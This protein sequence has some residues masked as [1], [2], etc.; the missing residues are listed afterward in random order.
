RAAAA[1]LEGRIVLISD[2]SPSAL[3]LP[4]TL[5]SLMQTGDDYYGNFEIASLLRCIRFSAIFLAFSLPGLYLAVT[6][7]HPQLLPTPLAMSLA[8]A[9]Q[10]VPYPGMGEV[11]FLEFSFELLREA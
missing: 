2:N 4:T 8:Q 9:R 7:F 3:L 10:G 1:L 6:G 11:L 5:N